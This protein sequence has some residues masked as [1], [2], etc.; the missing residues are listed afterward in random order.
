MALCGNIQFPNS[1]YSWASLGG[2]LGKRRG[3]GGGELWGL[4]A[5][6]IAL[7]LFIVPLRRLFSEKEIDIFLFY[8]STILN[9]PSLS[10]HKGHTV[11]CVTVRVAAVHEWRHP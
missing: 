8:K 1:Q 10:F 5:S 4:G 2:H 6:W 11:L 9:S 3:L 7:S